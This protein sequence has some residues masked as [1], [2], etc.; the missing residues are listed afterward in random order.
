MEPTHEL[1]YPIIKSFHHFND[2]L[3]LSVLP[4]VIFT[5]Q[6]KKGIMGF[7]APERWG[8]EGGD[9]CGE[10]S[11]NPTYIAESSLM[12]VMQTL[13]HEMVHYWQFVYGNPSRSNYHNKEWSLKMQGVGLMPSSTGRKGGETTGQN[14]SEYVIENGLFLQSFKRL[15]ENNS[16]KL[17]WVDRY[18]FPKLNYLL[19]ELEE[20]VKIVSDNVASETSDVEIERT[21]EAFHNPIKENFPQNFVFQEISKKQ[22]RSKYVCPSCEI[23]VYGKATLNISCD[24]CNEKLVKDI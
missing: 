9:T 7:F 24:D 16:F 4:N 15:V 18:S 6:R 8:N 21:L 23:I 13:V 1:M 14:M 20:D 12:E 11:I 19:E 17:Q 10:I 2:E 3:F 5:F 22:T